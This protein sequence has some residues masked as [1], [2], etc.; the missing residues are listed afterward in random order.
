[1][2]ASV[3]ADAAFA[4]EHEIEPS[5]A[6]WKPG[7]RGEPQEARL[8]AAL[9][10]HAHQLFANPARALDRNPVEMLRAHHDR[11]AVAL[12]RIFHRPPVHVLPCRLVAVDVSPAFH[13]LAAPTDPLPERA[14]VL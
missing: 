1:M 9:G 6:G 2:T 11:I 4:G 14:L 8:A 7:F 5:P 13:G 3:A 10:E 12:R